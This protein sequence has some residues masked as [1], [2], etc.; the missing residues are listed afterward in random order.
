MIFPKIIDGIL[1]G[2]GSGVVLSLLSA[3]VLFVS[4][5]K[6]RRNQIQYIRSLIFDFRRKILAAEP[7]RDYT[8]QDVQKA[9]FD[10]M[11]RQLSAA[12][13]GRATELSFDEVNAIKTIV[14]GFADLFPQLILNEE[15]YNKQI[16]F[17]LEA[18]KWLKLPPTT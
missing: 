10:D 9:Y 8:R 3:V 5:W 1:I 12:L 11:K 16:F 17:K 2:V 7:F 13:E 6:R 15:G 14:V 4:R 18:V